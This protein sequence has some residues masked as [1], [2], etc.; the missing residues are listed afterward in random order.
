MKILI[1]LVVVAVAC[2]VLFATGAL[3]PRRS[4]HLQKKVDD[5]SKKAERKG[6]ENAGP[7]GD[8]SGKG[9]R[10]ARKAADRSGEAGRTVH[11]KATPE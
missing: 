7:L 6:Y 1:L 4:R 11:E 5:K 8:M 9:F 3:S 10:K 2:A